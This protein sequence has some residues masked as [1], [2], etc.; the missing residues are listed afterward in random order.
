LFALQGA[1]AAIGLVCAVDVL[2]ALTLSLPIWDHAIVCGRGTW[3]VHTLGVLF[4]AAVLRHAHFALLGILTLGAPAVFNALCL[5]HS[6]GLR[7]VPDLS[8]FRLGG[9]CGLRFR[10]LRR[11]AVFL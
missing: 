7:L 3:V 1:I 11:G 8:T 4:L 6:V 5:T 2:G 10:C 9:S